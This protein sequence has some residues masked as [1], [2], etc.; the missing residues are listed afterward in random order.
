MKLPLLVRIDIIDHNNLEFIVGPTPKEL[1]LVG[2]LYVQGFNSTLLYT[3]LET[4]KI[5]SFHI[6]TGC[7]GRETEKKLKPG[8][9]IMLGRHSLVGWGYDKAIIQYLHPAQKPDRKFAI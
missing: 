2:R 5:N 8:Q 6:N 1:E 4:E 3:A 9:E 7:L